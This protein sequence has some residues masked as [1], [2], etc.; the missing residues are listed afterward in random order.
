MSKYQVQWLDRLQEVPQS[1]WDELALPLATPFLEWEWLNNLETSGSVTAETGWLP[2]HLTVWSGGTSR[3][4]ATVSLFS[5][6][7][8]Q[9]FLSS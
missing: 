5:T 8:G 9:R 3:V 7:S 1:A 4:T 2:K 6:S